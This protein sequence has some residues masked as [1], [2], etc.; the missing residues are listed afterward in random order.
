MRGQP[1]EWFEI[2]Y[3][4]AASTTEEAEQLAPRLRDRGVRSLL[5]VTSESHT[6]R[7]GRAFRSRLGSEI[8]VTVVGVPDPYFRVDGWW[9]HHEGREIVFIEWAKTLAT[10][11]GL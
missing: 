10:A 3:I 6:R 4:E 5:L 8:A 2:A 9:T 7:A 11:V 1:R